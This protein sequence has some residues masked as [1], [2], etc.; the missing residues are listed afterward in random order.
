MSTE[1][2]EKLVEL[3]TFIGR[4]LVDHPDELTIEAR[5]TGDHETLVVRVN[6]EDFGRVIG[7]QGRTVKALRTVVKYA[8]ARQ[9]ARVTLE[10][11][12]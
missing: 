3:A 8:A 11:E 1:N 10:V 9:D 7:R 5:E 12:E 6:P 2:Q 4:R